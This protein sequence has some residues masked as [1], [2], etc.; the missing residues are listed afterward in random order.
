MYQK[1]LSWNNK[2]VHSF[3]YFGVKIYDEQ[4]A[5]CADLKTSSKICT[6]RHKAIIFPGANFISALFAHN[7]AL[8]TFELHLSTCANF[9]MR[10]RKI[11]LTLRAI[12]LMDVNFLIRTFRKIFQTVLPDLSAHNFSHICEISN[13]HPSNYLHVVCSLYLVCNFLFYVLIIM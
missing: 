1:D 6:D 13:F 3:S 4:L 7:H 5:Y 2:Q 11:R 8:K 9:Y 12:F 10:I